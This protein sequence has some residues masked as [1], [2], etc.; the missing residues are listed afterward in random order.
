MGLA[1]NGH[2]SFSYGRPHRSCPE[3][4]RTTLLEG[5]KGRGKEKYTLSS[6]LEFHVAR[7]TRVSGFLILDYK[8]TVAFIDLKVPKMCVCV[9]A[10][11]SDSP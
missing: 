7:S 1:T 2:K 10:C 8:T 9:C 6:H 11:V 5:Q 4:G 3:R